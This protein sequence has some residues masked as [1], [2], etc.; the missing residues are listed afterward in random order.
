MRRGLASLLEATAADEMMLT[1]MV[2][3][4]ADRLDSFERVAALARMGL[5]DEDDLPE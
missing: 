3:D 5:G 4:P 2:F 1:T